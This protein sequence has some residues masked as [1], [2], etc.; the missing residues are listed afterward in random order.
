MQQK[1]QY[2]LITGA[3]SGI[4]RETAIH[5]SSNYNLILNGR[6]ERRLNET[7]ALCGN[8]RGHLVFSFDLARLEEIERAFAGFAA[9]NAAEV[10][11]FVHCA[12]FMKMMPLK[13]ASL[14]TINTTFAV[15]TI[16]AILLAKTL[17][18]RKINGGALKS[19]VFVSSNVS[20]F[21]AKAFS[22]YAASKAALDAAMRCLAVE[23][24]PKVRFN[25]VLPGAI[26]TEMTADIFAGKEVTDRIAKDYP[27]G[28]GEA[29][30]VAEM[31][32]FLLSEK[33][34]WITGQQFV[35]DG[36]RT[37]NISG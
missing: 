29:R 11:H 9:D 8:E 4:G 15:N 13:T 12:G 37:V 22:T 34:K 26:P 35:V 3:S 31:I 10:A 28:L 30:D 25:S 2:L 18:Q 27:L 6:D 14:E 5:L 17:V 33:S 32:E 7:K 1:N 23:L 16:S 20:N 19:V 24:A 36:G 21:G